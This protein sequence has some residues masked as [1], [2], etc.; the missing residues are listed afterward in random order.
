MSILSRSGKQPGAGTPH[1]G[2]RGRPKRDLLAIVRKVQGEFS[3]G[4]EA[5]WGHLKQHVRYIGNVAKDLNAAKDACASERG[6]SADMSQEELDY[7]VI[8]KQAHAMAT[9]GGA[10][11]KHGAYTKNLVEANSYS[12]KARVGVGNQGGL[13]LGWGWT[14]RVG[15][16]WVGGA[17]W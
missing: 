2:K 17:R 6:D 13:R 12:K 3:A 4:D 11:Q 5:W 1:S 9:I 15:L 7:M 8:A 16:G 10:F 14:N